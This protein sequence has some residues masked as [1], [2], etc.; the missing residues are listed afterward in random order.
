MTENTVNSRVLDGG[1][2]RTQKHRHGGD[3][4]F[5]SASAHPTN[6]S[7]LLL[8]SPASSSTVFV[9]PSPCMGSSLQVTPDTGGACDEYPGGLTCYSVKYLKL[10][11]QAIAEGWLVCAP[12]PEACSLGSVLTAQRLH[13]DARPWEPGNGTQSC[14]AAEGSPAIKHGGEGS[15]N[16]RRRSHLDSTEVSRCLLCFTTHSGSSA[17]L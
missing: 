4:T 3:G 2:T 13:T 1:A 9:L 17:Q 11:H 6:T 15:R 5:P 12:T 7:W 10:V 16:N 8:L 14:H